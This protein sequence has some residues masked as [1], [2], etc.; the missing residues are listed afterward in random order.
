MERP[1]SKRKQPK[2][3]PIELKRSAAQ[4]V[5]EEQRSCADVG[6]ELGICSR[7]IS[8]WVQEYKRAG[9]EAFPQKGHL[10]PQD[11]KFRQMEAKLRRV[12]ME[13]D[14]LKKAIAYFAE[15]PK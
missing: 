10:A 11:E 12:T 13:R 6:R 5:T 3:Y 14:I 1:E 15:V 2:I 7:L 8:R 4:L 9:M